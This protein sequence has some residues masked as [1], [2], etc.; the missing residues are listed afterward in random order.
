M[1]CEIRR[2]KASG[3]WVVFA[4]RRGRRPSDFKSGT[5]RPREDAPRRDP[6]CPFCPGNERSLPPVIEQAGAGGYGRHEV[7]IETPRHD[8]DPALMSARELRAMMEA[9]YKTYARLMKDPRNMLVLIFRNHGE[10]AGTSLRHL[11]SQII[12]TGLV[13][14]HVRAAGR[15]AQRYF[16]QHGSCA[17]CDALRFEK[18]EKRRLLFANR[19]FLCFVPYAAEVPCEMWIVP[20]RH[21]ACF[22]GTTV[23]DRAALAEILGRALRTLRARLGDPDYNYVLMSAPRNRE[24]DPHLHW[25][26]R[27]RPRLTTRA[28][29]EIGSG[30]LINPSL[31][32]DDRDFLK[33]KGRKPRK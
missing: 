7:I 24:A 33:G 8:R 2:N 12:A 11:H 25:Y 26:L 6:D 31:P 21:W 1:K 19:H 10:G 5:A 32:E 4:P 13:P 17:F 15:E 30:M 27:I 23:R 20:K 29:F 3:E 18:K 16:D 9:Y 14:G 28:G 22:G